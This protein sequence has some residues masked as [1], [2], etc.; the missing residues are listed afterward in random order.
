MKK[1]I[2]II[3]ILLTGAFFRFY[4]LGNVSRGMQPDEA[5]YAYDG[6]SIAQTGTDHRQTGHP[7]LYLRGYSTEWDNRTSVIYPY[8]L[9]GLFHFLPLNLWTER[10]P[11]AVAGTLIVNVFSPATTG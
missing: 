1:N 10:F 6:W 2:V 3:L 7:P 4:D 5:M 8:I 9:A 11:A